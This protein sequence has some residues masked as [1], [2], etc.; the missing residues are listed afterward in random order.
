MFNINKF[1][2]MTGFEPRTSGIGSNCSTNWAT[3]TSHVSVLY[4]YI[5]GHVTLKILII[6][7]LSNSHFLPQNV[8]F[9]LSG[10]NPGTSFPPHPRCIKRGNVRLWSDKLGCNSQ[11]VW[12][13]WAIFCT[14]GNHSKLVAKIIL[15]KLPT[16]L[17]N[18]CKG[19][20][21]F[22]FSCEIIFRQFL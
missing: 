8:H 18:F 12:P 15:P 13:D 11:P 10:L 7:P 3:T 1:L 2:P 6:L 21:T 20:K 14:L 4:V 5:F 22:H 17:G 16:L 9:H 19:A